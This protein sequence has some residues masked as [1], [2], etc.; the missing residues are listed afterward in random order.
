LK[1][2]LR[3]ILC[4]GETKAEKD[5]DQTLE[6]ITRQVKEALA[7]ISRTKANQIIIAY[8][9]VWSVGTDALPTSNEVMGAKLLIR[10]ILHELFDK[11]Y[12]E[13]VAILYGGSVNAKS[14]KQVCVDSEVDGALIGRESL[15]PHEF[16][17]IAEIINNNQ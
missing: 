16:V 7:E 2:G 17:K 15:Q 3:P 6:V 8:E 5:A 11:K 10:K 12:A 9:P 1:H 4:V 14:V 13:E